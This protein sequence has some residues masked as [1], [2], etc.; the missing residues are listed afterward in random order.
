VGPSSFW[1]I[2]LFIHVQPTCLFDLEKE[3]TE[4]MLVKK[5]EKGN[6]FFIRSSRMVCER[7]TLFEDK[8]KRT[9][10]AVSSSNCAFRQHS[11]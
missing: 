7:E 9:C 3:E 10:P 4:A 5:E 8:K 6:I 11:L 1:L 2:A